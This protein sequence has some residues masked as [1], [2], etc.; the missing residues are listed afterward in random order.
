MNRIVLLDEIVQ[1]FALMN[2]DGLAGFF[3]ERLESRRVSAAF[4]DRDL[5]GKPC[6]L[7]A[8]L[9]KHGA[10]C[11]SRQAVSTQLTETD[12]PSTNA[13]EPFFGI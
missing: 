10:A 9:K 5:V 3:L 12:G 11:L 13:T 2:F 1:V 4:I 7:T 8:F 6:C